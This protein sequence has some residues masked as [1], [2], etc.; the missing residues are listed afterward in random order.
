M[1][2]SLKVILWGEEIGRLVWDARRRLSYFMYNPTFLKKGLNISPLVAPVDEVKRLTPVWG[3][4]A[5]IYQ[6]LPAFI[7]DSLP[8]AWENQLFDFLLKT[9][10]LQ[11]IAA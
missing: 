6:K 5:K 8:D 1:V 11:R 4:E 7:A 9:N 2:Q 10:D 3:E